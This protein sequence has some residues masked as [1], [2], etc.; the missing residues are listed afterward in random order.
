[1]VQDCCQRLARLHITVAVKP[2][3][4]TYV[5][6]HKLKSAPGRR[7]WPPLAAPGCSICSTGSLN[8]RQVVEAHMNGK[9]HNR[10]SGDA[11]NTQGAGGGSGE[12]AEKYVME[13]IIV[14]S[15]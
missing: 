7:S 10:K 11:G 14:Y 15:I 8:A 13:G 2:A 1:M 12:L 9:E 3:G 6:A 5:K 4:A